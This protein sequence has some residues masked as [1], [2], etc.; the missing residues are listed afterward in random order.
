MSITSTTDSN[1]TAPTLLLQGTHATYAYRRVGGGIRRPLLCLQHLTGTLDNWDPA[2]TDLPRADREV[3]LFDGAGVGRSTGT[4]PADG[5]RNGDPWARFPGCAVLRPAATYSDSRPAEWSCSRWHSAAPRS[6]AK[7]FSWVPLR[8]AVRTS[9]TSRSR[10]WPGTSAI[11]RSK[12]T[13]RC[14]NSFLRRLR[15]ARRR[16]ERFL[17]RLAQR[18]ED[19]DTPSGPDVA[20]AQMAA[21]REWEQAA[22]ARFVDLKGSRDRRRHFSL[23]LSVRALLKEHLNEHDQR[24]AARVRRLR[25]NADNR[26]SGD[27]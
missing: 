2:V 11:R 14:R 8:E 19:L 22:G 17:E 23:P 26:P 27:R 5:G 15:P 7:R 10:A 3:I 9:C 12:D 25:V 6:F 1:T 21:F 13:Q 24:A 16:A 4:V 20:A 18:K